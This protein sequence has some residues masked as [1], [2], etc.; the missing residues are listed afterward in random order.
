MS[1][2]SLL[3]QSTNGQ[4]TI[5]SFYANGG[6]VKGTATLTLGAT[7]YYIP[8][9]PGA[10]LNTTAVV[11]ALL[12]DPDGDTQNWIVYSEPYLGTK[13]GKYYIHVSFSTAVENAGVKIAWA[14]LAPSSTAV[15]AGSDSP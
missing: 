9:P 8:T 11:N 12:Q 2:S 4:F 15:T 14:V 7:D 10:I 1:A 13:D 3:L 6:I 5:P